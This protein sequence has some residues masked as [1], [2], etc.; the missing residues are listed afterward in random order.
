[1][2][3][4]I[5]VPRRD[6]HGHRDRVWGWV[7]TWWQEQLP[8][9]PIFEGHHT[10]GLF[11]RSAACNR[12]AAKAGAWDVA[13][14]IDSDVICDPAQVR[15]AIELAAQW[16]DRLILPFSRRHNLTPRGTTRIM[17]GDRGSWQRYI[18]KTYTQMC[19]SVVV[20]PRQ[21][22]DTVGGFDE[23]FAGW[24]FEDT[25]FACACETFGT[26]LHKLDGECWHLWH[27]TAS[28]GRRDAPS[29]QSNR[30]RREQYS[31]SL[32]DKEAIR[33]LQRG[34]YIVR[35]DARAHETIPRILHR[36]VPASTSEEAETWW[37]RFGALHPGWTLL[38]HRD[39]LDPADWPL[40]AR[41]WKLCTSGAQFAGLIRL[42]ALWRWGGIYIDSD[43]EPYRSFEPLLPLRAFAAWEDAKVVPDA[44][45]GAE[46][47]HP[48]IRACL[49]L[50]LKRL[51]QG[52]WESGPGVTTTLLP[53]RSD[54]LL[55]PPGSFFPYHYHEKHR[56]HEDHAAAQPWAFAAH[57]WAGSWLPAEVEEWA[58]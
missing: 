6:D 25:A 10:E 48:A 41:S 21:L 35:P 36:V 29:F 19:S 45:L 15:E 56:R 57:H 5:L 2:K 42:E 28:E 53:G 7:Q 38:T 23:R 14:L 54:V 31:A 17:S 39:P 51:R 22:W 1:M 46:P 49:T 18:G 52:A 47:E 34:D 11:N 50:A 37:D 27:P 33:A 43:V 58:S 40:T 30:A 8:E 16:K 44:V 9:L 26:T 32:G 4:V 12:A 3:A 13:V 20:I 24:G 55:L